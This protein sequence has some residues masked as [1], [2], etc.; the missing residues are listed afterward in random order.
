METENDIIFENLH[1][2]RVDIEKTILKTDLRDQVYELSR[3]ADNIEK[4]LNNN[5]EP[6]DPENMI[7]G[8]TIGKL[9]YVKRKYT[10]QLGR[11]FIKDINKQIKDYKERIE[12]AKSMLITQLAV[13]KSYVVDGDIVIK[14]S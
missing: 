2:F 12:N 11:P 6:A 1:L 7:I 13:I 10:D 9:H 5:L 8:G 4:Y 14:K 3:V